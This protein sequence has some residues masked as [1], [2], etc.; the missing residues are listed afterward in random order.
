MVKCVS[1]L[2]VLMFRE[3]CLGTWAQTVAAM[4]RMKIRTLGFYV[5]FIITNSR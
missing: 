2:G 1:V 4:N 5:S 3:S